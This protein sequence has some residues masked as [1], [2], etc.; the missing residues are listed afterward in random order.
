MITSTI[1]GIS[2]EKPNVE[3]LTCRLAFTV[4]NCLRTSCNFL[5]CKFWLFAF[6]DMLSK[7]QQQSA[8]RQNATSFIFSGAVADT[9]LP[10]DVF[11]KI[12]SKC[13]PLCCLPFYTY[14]WGDRKTTR[15][16]LESCWNWCVWV[17]KFLFH[18][19]SPLRY[20]R[21]ASCCACV[22]PID[23]S[24]CEC[25][26]VWAQPTGNYRKTALPIFILNQW[27]RSF[28]VS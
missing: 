22:G 21:V 20:P 23:A 27:S 8:K 13:R 19:Q 14:P 9:R 10:K 15:R 24:V 28:T 5:L 25:K 4:F 7:D 6:A 12:Y 3:E 18:W 26:L 16:E 1:H 17:M 11:R 2:S